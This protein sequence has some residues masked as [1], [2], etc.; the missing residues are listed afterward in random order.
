MKV[1]SLRLR[2]ARR[3]EVP[4]I[5]RF[6]LDRMRPKSK[7]EREALPIPSLLEITTAID[8]MEFIVLEEVDSEKIVATSGIFRLVNHDRGVFGELSGMLT[9]REVGGL[10]PYRVQE[11]MIAARIARAA[12][13][14]LDEVAPTALASFVASANSDSRT[15]LE[16]RG[17]E[18]T[19]ALPAWLRDEYVSWFGWD[20]H[21]N[22]VCMRVGARALVAA[23][24][25]VLTLERHR[26]H[27]LRRPTSDGG[28]EHFT[29]TWERTLWG[30]NLSDLEAFRNMTPRPEFPPLV[31]EITFA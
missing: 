19:A 5:K 4:A 14:L 16:R 12:Q 26:P 21:E 20:G 2:L 3:S 18:E 10:A 1:K 8:E 11:I 22:W 15:N 29:L 23:A 24:D 7:S 13:A 9:G 6:Y 25:I 27:P 31:D 17:L 28:T 30:A